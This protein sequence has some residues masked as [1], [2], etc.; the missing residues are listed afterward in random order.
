ML[1]SSPGF[2]FGF[3]P[4]FFALYCTARSIERKNLV[5]AVFSLV[6]Y[7]VGE[8]L[9]IFLMILSTAGN[10]RVAQKIVQ[11]EGNDRRRLTA[12][13]IAA[14]LLLLGI[15]KYAGFVMATVGVLLQPLGI[16]V[17]VPKIALPLGI[18]FF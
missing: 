11:C 4:V 13:S 17:P 1:F 12:I 16:P 8:P 2:L 14:N 6:F 3:L 7:S 15:F 9:F 10:F 18:S 5:L